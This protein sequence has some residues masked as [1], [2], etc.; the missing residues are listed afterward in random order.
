MFVFVANKIKYY[1]KTK[2]TRERE[3]VKGRRRSRGPLTN[4]TLQHISNY[5][6]L[7]RELKE[8]ALRFFIQRMD[9]K[10]EI[11]G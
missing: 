3:R 9:S 5:S 8:R 6:T 4:K 1:K 2:T 10:R 7:K 11:I